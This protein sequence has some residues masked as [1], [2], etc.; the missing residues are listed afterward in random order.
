MVVNGGIRFITSDDGTYDASHNLDP[1]VTLPTNQWNHIA[2]EKEGNTGKVYQNGVCVGIN[3]NFPTSLYSNVNDNLLVG[4]GIAT[5]MGS[6]GTQFTDGYIQDLRVYKG[7]AKYKGGFDI[8]K[9]YTPV[10]IGTWRQVPDT[11]KNNFATLNPLNCYGGTSSSATLT[12]GNLTLTTTNGN[13][14]HRSSTIGITTGKWYAEV[15]VQNSQTLRIGVIAD[16]STMQETD[17]VGFSRSEFSYVTT[18][19]YGFNDALP[20]YGDTYTNNDVISIA[21]NRTDGTITFFKN[22]VSQGIA[23]DIL[24]NG[25]YDDQYFH[26][27]SADSSLTESGVFSWNFGQNPTF[28]GNVSAAS[29]QRNADS[30]GKGEFRYEPP[31][32]FLALCEDNLPTPTIADPGEHFKTVLWTGVNDTNKIK[33]GFQPDFVW[34]KNRDY[35]NWHALY[36]SIRGLYLELNSNQN[37][38]DR[39][40]SSNDG[41]RSFDSDGFTSGLDDN[42]GGRSG[43]SYVAW[44]WKAGGAA[45]ANTDG[46]INSSVSANQTAGFS[47]VSYTGNNTAGATIGHGLGK[48][49]SFILLKERYS[50]GNSISSWQVYH[51]SL[52]ATQRI[53][54]NVS[55]AA[56]IVSNIWNDTEPTSDVFSIGSSGA[57]SENSGTYIAY[58]WAEIEGY[59]KFGKYIGN[60]NSD[61]P[62]VYLGFR[63]AWV[64]IKRTTTDGYYWTLFDNARKSTNPVNHTLNPDQANVEETD[65]GNGQIDFLSNGFKCRNTDG[66]I[67]SD[68][69]AYVYMAFAESPF[70][71]AN[72]K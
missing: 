38:A 21:L 70:Q 48:K 30:N 58:C 68:D 43:D 24:N 25:D 56:D 9:P 7:V 39:D 62:F 12:N 19:A 5:Y 49:P 65:G 31:S 27:I 57:V 46:S 11:C 52:G 14:G 63:P 44:C 47:I 13:R 6:N 3:T 40:R 2:V 8:P 51:S 66:G 29:T 67:N 26:F 54:L 34:I 18:G 59:S 28:S 53:Q 10:G 72:A 22:G 23:T 17:N 33:C 69:V 45:V 71:T 50:P 15:Q 35:V 16:K 64:L 20:A 41:L 37:S 42:A 60:G 61:G 36:D 4:A 55:D 1:D 32:G